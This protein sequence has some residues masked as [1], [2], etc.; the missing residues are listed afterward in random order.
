[1]RNATEFRRQNRLHPVLSNVAN[2]TVASSCENS[3]S[4]N[5]PH[6][7]PLKSVYLGQIFDQFGIDV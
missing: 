3:R 6:I 4:V 5:A 7:L 2:A 1:M